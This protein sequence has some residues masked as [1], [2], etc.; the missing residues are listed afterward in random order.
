MGTVYRLAKGVSR[1]DQETL[2][3]FLMD[4]PSCAP[5]IIA[6]AKRG[7][8]A[9]GDCNSPRLVDLR[10][11]QTAHKSCITQQKKAKRRKVN[12]QHRMRADSSKARESERDR[13]RES[14][15]LQSNN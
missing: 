6:I 10:V 11:L 9:N 3:E 5:I 13:K 8:D 12:H 14:A 4:R 15:Q 7:C 2:R 1:L